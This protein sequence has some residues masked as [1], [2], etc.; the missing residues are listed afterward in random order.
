MSIERFG[1][2]VGF[3][4]SVADLLRGPYKPVQDG[5]VMLPLTVLRRLD[6]VLADTKPSV[7]QASRALEDAPALICEV[8]LNRITGHQFHD[9]RQYDFQKQLGEPDKLAENLSFYIDSFSGKAKQFL[10]H[11]RH[12]AAGSNPHPPA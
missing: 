12:E 4:W 3:I 1:D 2:K 9:T 6:C 5:E 10:E 11:F 8:R 7:L